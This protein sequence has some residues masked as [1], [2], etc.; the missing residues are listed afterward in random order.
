MSETIQKSLHKFTRGAS[1]LIS[2]LIFVYFAI[3]DNNFEY[4]IYFTNWGM[5][6]TL[7]YFL[8]SL[9]SYHFSFDSVLTENFLVIWVFNWLITLAFWGYLYPVEG[10]T[11]LLRSSITHSLPLLLTLIEYQQL[12]LSIARLDYIYPLG[13]L[14]SYL[15]FVLVPYTLVIGPI[16]T[17]IDFQNFFSVIFCT[18]L[19]WLAVAFLELINVAKVKESTEEIRFA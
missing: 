8:L 5:F 16:Y 2:T 7:L 3:E 12:K 9:I 15:Y 11:Y 13:V 17:G 1:F 19:F 18:G 10:S 14:L 6:L 4:F